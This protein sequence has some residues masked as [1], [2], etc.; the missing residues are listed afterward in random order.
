[1]QTK[2]HSDCTLARPLKR[3]WRKPMACLIWPKTGSTTCL[4]SRYGLRQPPL[5]S[6]SRMLSIRVPGLPF[7]VWVAALVPCFWRPVAI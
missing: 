1:M 7:F 3:N 4:R 5:F 6:F 2:L